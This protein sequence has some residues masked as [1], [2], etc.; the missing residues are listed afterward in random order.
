[1]I[2]VK[3]YI[4]LFTV[5]CVFGL[6]TNAQVAVT[7]F[8]PYDNEENLVVDVLLGSGIVASNFSSVGFANGIGYFDGFNS[9]IGFDEGVILST[10]GL[11]MVTNGFGI[12][13]GVSGDS[14]LE[15][16]L[17]AIN[18]TWGVNNVT[19]LEF[20]FVAESES[21]A[22]NYVFGSTEYTSFTCSSYNDIFGFFLS[23][24]GIAG[25][26][27]N[28]AVNLA[29]VPD[30]DN[31]GTYTTTPVAVN[32]INAGS[33]VYTD[34]PTCD[35]IDPNFESYN[36]YWIDNDYSG[37]GWDGPNQPPS[38][39][40]TVAGITGFTV[41]LTAEY[42]DLICG[43]TYHIKLA[44]A[45][46]ADA[47]LNS[48]VFLEANS[49]ASPE[50]QI[51]TVP[52]AES[53][54][55]S[56]VENGVL[57]GCGEVALQFV[58]SGDMTMDLNITLEYSG[59]AEYGVDYNELPTEMVLPAFQDQ[60]IIPIDVFYDLIPEGQETLIVTVSG[61]P[62]ACEEV[63][64]QDIE[65]IIFDQQE[66]LVE[67]IPEQAEINCFGSADITAFILGG[68]PPYNYSWY[69]ESGDLIESGELLEEGSLTINQS[70]EETTFYTLVISDACSDQ[71]STTPVDVIV[72]E[73]VMGVALNED[74]LICA[75]EIQDI[76]LTPTTSGVPPYIFTWFYDGVVVSDSESLQNLSGP[77]LYQLIVEDACGAIAGDEQ[78]VSFIELQ[79]YV[80]IMSDDVL[81][82]NLLPEGCFESVLQ[83]NVQEIQDEDVTV[84]F[85]L[86]GSAELGLDY[87]IE[88]TT[89]TIPAGEESVFLPIS[90]I[91]DS[92]EEGVES[93]EF[94]FP[95]I[96]ACSDFPTQIIVQ[97]Y[98]PPAVSV[99]LEDELILC[100]DQSDTGILEG[101]ISGGIGVVNYNWYYNDEMISTDL[102]ITT[103]G[104]EPGFYSLV[105]IDQCGNMSS[106]SIYFDT[107]LLAPVVTLSSDF[108][109]DPAQLNEGCGLSLL[110][111]SLPYSTDEDRTY[112]LDLDYGLE[113][114]NGFDVQEIPQSIVFPAG[115]T[116]VEI[117]IV[118]ILDYLSE[119]V[120]EIVF[121]FPFNNNCSSTDDIIVS[122]D[123]YD[124]LEIIMPDS[125]TLCVGQSLELQAD[126][127]GGIPP[128]TTS[129]SYLNDFENENNIVFDVEEGEFPAFFT[130]T[131]A[132]GLSASSEVLI[133]G[134]EIDNFEVIWPPNEI[135]ACFG[136]NSIISLSIEGGLEPFDFQWF[137]D[138]QET[139]TTTT[140]VPEDAIYG[141][142][143]YG[144]DYISPGSTQ[145]IP[146]SPQY[147]PYVYD[148]QV[149]ITDSCDNELE[150]NI[151]VT[152]DDCMLPTAF[153]PN[154]DGNNDIFWIDF[155][156][157]SEP[158]GLD[159][160]NRWGAL[161]YRTQDYTPCAQFQSDCWDGTHFGTYGD[162]CSDGIYYY[163]LTY[164][165]P[166]QNADS[167]DVSNF[168]ES[169][170][171]KPH[172]NSV[173][174]Q[175]SGSILLTR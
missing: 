61:V 128:Y 43:E 149:F 3:R 164:S 105:A 165:R 168:V 104:L 6:M 97:I 36:I 69:S 24:P 135:F 158:V 89:I 15:L 71:E 151:E 159:I 102:D 166:I 49:F 25:P 116:S 50:V 70:P 167:Y 111:F 140:L 143:W 4:V 92:F 175:R 155:G 30:P 107:E 19:V 68:Y 57:E 23:G 83:F 103:E 131:D 95:F 47:A 90:I 27:S 7:N 172:N 44:I 11:E 62:V 8:P 21:M 75:E 99:D 67:M 153:T 157:L 96:D 106:E 127:S 58:R 2:S 35:A 171:G 94:N 174:R 160:F 55:V 117:E 145:V 144:D 133:E 123:N 42:N 118:P 170:F 34:N 156:D 14:D 121:S 122:I 129:W 139:S 84:T 114:L 48:A 37:N 31:P 41:P 132:C 16:A 126:F 150:Y 79:P 86:S 100:E 136:D 110:T 85:E 161:V 108:Y 80:E 40:F 124:A 52:N 26:Y 113:F 38:P 65:L 88:S 66:L 134:V 101:F 5:L 93:I 46:A 29:Y 119:E 138:G 13:S 12:G 60:V 173:G 17:N 9:N 109:D 115:T 98:E 163:T 76:V 33:P 120:E 28:N 130:V 39:E 18:L 73:D 137:L 141:P 59:D 78:M 63:T 91:P 74:L 125:Q 20:D 154:G 82:P 64:V 146:T 54:L 152:V 142:I 22:F 32:T 169:V 81:N 56:T 112:W 87:S 162:P 10:G 45:D 147:T 1:M 72:N 53:G 77:G 51:S 148:Y